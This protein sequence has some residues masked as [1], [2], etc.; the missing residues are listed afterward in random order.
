[1]PGLLFVAGALV[2]AAV[3][4]L[5]NAFTRRRL[6]ILMF[7]MAIPVAVYVVATILVPAYVTNFIVKPN[8]LGREGPYIEHNITWTRRAF[9]I[10]RIE[11]RTFVGEQLVYALELN[12]GPTVGIMT[13][14]RAA[15]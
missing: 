4:A 13:L 11:H 7:G 1:M 14:G 10:D 9:G 3:I 15:A 8:E 2:L 6:R 12:I 5:V